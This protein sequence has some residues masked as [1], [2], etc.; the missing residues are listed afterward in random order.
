M[1]NTLIG[2]HNP[3]SVVEVRFANWGDNQAMAAVVVLGLAM[4]EKG[5]A[6]H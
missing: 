4:G 3:C 5:Y 2:A 1:D 6:L